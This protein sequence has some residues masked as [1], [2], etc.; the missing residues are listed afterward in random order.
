MTRGEKRA[1]LNRVLFGASLY[2]LDSVGQH[3]AENIRK[4]VGRKAQDN[5]VNRPASTSDV[6]SEAS[7]RLEGDNRTIHDNSRHLLDAVG[8]AILGVGVG[9]GIGLMLAPASGEETR[10]NIEQRIW[11]RFFEEKIV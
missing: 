9:V 3:L 1:L 2:V 6:H 4:K 11:S 10:R 7:E 5:V 8:A